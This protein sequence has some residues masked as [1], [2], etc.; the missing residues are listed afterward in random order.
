MS[1]TVAA[2][3]LALP[4]ALLFVMPAAVACCSFLVSS[5]L[6]A[7]KAEA[8]KRKAAETAAA[9]RA[10]AD[11]DEAEPGEVGGG[12]RKRPK[13]EPIVWHSP[14]KQGG[15]QADRWVSRWKVGP[16]RVMQTAAE[17][18]PVFH[19]GRGGFVLQVDTFTAERYSSQDFGS[20]D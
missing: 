9:E 1:T 12:P 19:R 18:W 14:P 2:S 15:S 7:A 13:H 11:A 8:A 5:V 17:S 3:G 20:H 16:N 4:Y 6:E 10:G